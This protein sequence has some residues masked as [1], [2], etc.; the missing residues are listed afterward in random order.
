[1]V[2]EDTAYRRSGLP[3][4]RD[5]TSHGAQVMSHATGNARPRRHPT[6]AGRNDIAFVQLPAN[7]LDDPSGRWVD[8]YALDGLHAIL[9]YARRMFEQPAQHVTI[10]FS[11]G[12]QTG[13]HDGSS[14]FEKAVDEMIEKAEKD[15][16]AWQLDVVVPSGNSH[17]LRAHAEF[18]FDLGPPQDPLTW[19][20]SPDSQLP[21]YLEI[22]PPAGVTLTELDVSL[23]SPTGERITAIDQAP[24]YSHDRTVTVTASPYCGKPNQYL[25]LMVIAATARPQESNAPVLPLAVPGRWKVRVTV[26]PNQVV[27]GTAHAYLARIDPNLGRKLRGHSGYLDSRN[28]DPRR[29]LR[30]SPQLSVAEPASPVEVMARGSLNGI[31]T[32]SRVQVA[33]GYVGSSQPAKVVRAPSTYSSG[34]PSRGPRTGPDFA[35]PTDDSPVLAGRLAGGNRSGTVTRL[36]GTSFAAPMYALDLLDPGLVSDLPLAGPKP[37]WFENRCGKGERVA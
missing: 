8:H 24:A 6:L 4:L 36:V 37:K 12:P 21:S 25:V 3:S 13:P 7:A 11:Y 32:G 20:V 22:W 23:T 33:A 17:L 5:A 15:S 29:Y 16:P 27:A 28:Y 2:D 1:V 34:G 35:Y 19:C 18:D 31:A 14:I 9:F 30:A 26:R 10:N